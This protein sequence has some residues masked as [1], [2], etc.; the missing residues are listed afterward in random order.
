M[1]IKI[2]ISKIKSKPRKT[3]DLLEAVHY[4]LFVDTGL[5][6]MLHP[7]EKPRGSNGKT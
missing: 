4:S 5:Y 3:Q 2:F 6:S 1:K 7:P